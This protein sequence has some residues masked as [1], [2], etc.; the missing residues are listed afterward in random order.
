MKIKEI[1][2]SSAISTVVTLAAVYIFEMGINPVKKEPEKQESLE[3]MTYPTDGLKEKISCKV[4]SLKDAAVKRKILSELE[5]R[6]IS[7]TIF[8]SKG[9][10]G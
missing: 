4:Q 6:D 1:L 3:I 2:L 9:E 7:I 8:L 10:N 5:K